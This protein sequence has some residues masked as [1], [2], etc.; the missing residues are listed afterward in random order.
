M[1]R[2]E[3]AKN[4]FAQKCHCSQAVLASFADVLGITEETALKFGS[5]FGGGMRKGEVCGACT[6]ALM[7]LGMKFGMSEVGDT[8]NQQIAD[9]YARRFLDEFAR[10]NGSYLCRDLLKRNLA[11]DEERQKAREEGL[12]ASVCPKMIESAVRISEQMM[13]EKA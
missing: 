4:Y 12:F 9:G 3:I 2:T 1:E 7:A 5:C 13:Q 10:Q 6:G 8:E 11:S